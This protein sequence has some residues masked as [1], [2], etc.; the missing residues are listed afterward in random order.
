MS[1]DLAS[2]RWKFLLLLLLLLC[3]GVFQTKL[4]KKGESWQKREAGEGA[5]PL[6]LSELKLVGVVF[7]SKAALIDR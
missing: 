7:S 4:K 2:P 5:E 3:I 6:G 1:V